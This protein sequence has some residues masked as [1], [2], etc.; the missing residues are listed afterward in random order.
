M[1]KGQTLF[2]TFPTASGV[3]G[4]FWVSD[5]FSDKKHKRAAD[6]PRNSSMPLSLL[7]RGGPQ[8]NYK[9]V[10][11]GISPH[12]ALALRQNRPGFLVPCKVT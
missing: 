7:S 2:K 6:Q 12:A 5:S 11:P 9:A 3:T 8:Q 1:K 4:F 10:W